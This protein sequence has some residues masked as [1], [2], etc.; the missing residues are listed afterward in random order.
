MFRSRTGPSLPKGDYDQGGGSRVVC[1]HESQGAGLPIW[2]LKNADQLGMEFIET[3]LLI[4][5]HTMTTAFLS[6]FAAN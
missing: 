3:I 2:D 6:I 1:W 4:S 5:S